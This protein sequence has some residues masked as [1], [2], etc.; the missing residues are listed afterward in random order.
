MGFWLYSTFLDVA[1]MLCIL[2][3]ARHGKVLTVQGVSNCVL[4]FSGGRVIKVS[5]TLWFYFTCG[6][7]SWQAGVYCQWG[8]LV[9][10]SSPGQFE[11]SQFGC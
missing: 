10:A 2:H 11:K 6:A 5:Y 8:P 7:A 9:W 1:E 3:C 4:V